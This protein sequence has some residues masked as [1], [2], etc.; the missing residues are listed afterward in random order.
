[1]NVGGMPWTQD[2]EGFWLVLG[3]C[4]FLIAI[5]YIVLRRFRIL[6]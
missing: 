4:G 6:P 2:A 3:F 5:S 1:M